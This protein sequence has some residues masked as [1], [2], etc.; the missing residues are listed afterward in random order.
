LCTARSEGSAWFHRQRHIP[1]GGNPLR[2]LRCIIPIVPARPL[3]LIRRVGHRHRGKGPPGV[4]RRH[5]CTSSSGR[6]RGAPA[7]RGIKWGNAKQT[8]PLKKR[9][10]RKGY[11]CSPRIHRERATFRGFPFLRHP[12]E[13]LSGGGGYGMKDVLGNSVCPG[14]LGNSM[15]ILP[16]KNLSR[17]PADP[18]WHPR[19][20][21]GS[22]FDRSSHVTTIRGGQSNRFLWPSPTS[23]FAAFVAPSDETDSRVRCRGA[24]ARGYDSDACTWETSHDLRQQYGRK[25]RMF[26]RSRKVPPLC[27][28]TRGRP[29]FGTEGRVTYLVEDGCK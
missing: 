6:P 12:L 21:R 25:I 7:H 1:I 14:V 29:A 4:P 13:K 5:A 23:F 19:G 16:A 18:G 20:R 24:A 10:E 8:P 11:P 3:P 17:V 15:L 28:R 2:P 22:F 9:K 26:E 27:H